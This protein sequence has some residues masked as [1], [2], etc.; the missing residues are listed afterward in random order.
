M[1]PVEG[2]PLIALAEI[3][4]TKALSRPLSL[5]SSSSGGR[6]VR[7]RMRRGRCRL[8]PASTRW[9]PIGGNSLGGDEGLV[10]LGGRILAG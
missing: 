10:R 8:P 9:N 7:V 1:I 5:F 3:W 2:T 6:P 4:V